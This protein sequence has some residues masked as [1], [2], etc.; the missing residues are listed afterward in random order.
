V[1]IMTSN[2]G[3]RELSATPIGFGAGA[4]GSP[5]AAVE[6]T[7]SPEFR[8]RL[9]AIIPFASLSEAV[10][11]RVVEKFLAELQERLAERGVT[12]ALTAA[13]RRDLARRGFDPL[14]GA[15]PLAR[16][17]QTG[18]GDVVAGEI[19]FGRLSRGGKVRIGLRDGKL[20]FAYV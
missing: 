2:A 13:A 11:E 14:Y 8:N 9:D 19:L 3:A 15:R 16:L 6:K 5:R 17:M 20:T 10:M 4:P 12:L 1:L 18:I 7:F